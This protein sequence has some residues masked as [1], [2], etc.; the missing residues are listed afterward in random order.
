LNYIY[1]LHIHTYMYYLATF[2]QTTMYLCTY[3]G[4]YTLFFWIKVTKNLDTDY[5]SKI[6][7][8]LTTQYSIYKVSCKQ[9]NLPRYTV[10]F[11]NS[12]PKW[13]TKIHCLDRIFWRN[14]AFFYAVYVFILTYIRFSI[15]KN[16]FVII[17]LKC[18]KWQCILS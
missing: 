13:L 2:F 16:I 15:K 12:R 10:S 18:T 5:Q 14:L 3:V 17:F 8:I 4:I 1:S 7:N 6:I 9:N 11:T